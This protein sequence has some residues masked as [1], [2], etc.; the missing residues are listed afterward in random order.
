MKTEILSEANPTTRNYRNI[1]NCVACHA[2]LPK[3]EVFTLGL[4]PVVEFPSEPEG[5]KLEAPLYLCECPSCKLVQLQH[6]VTPDLL[7]RDFWYK[8]AT[9]GS[10]RSALQEIHD[11]VVREVNPQLGDAVLDIGANDGTLLSMFPVTNLRVGF[12]PARNLSQG[13]SDKGIIIVPEYFTREH[14]LPDWQGRFKAVTAISMFYD[15]ENPGEF[16]E[17]VKYAMNPNGVFIVQ[18]N[19]LGAML[20]SLDVGNIVHEHLAYYSLQSFAKLVQNHGMAI[21]RIEFNDVNGGSVR[22]TVRVGSDTPSEVMALIQSEKLKPWREFTAGLINMRG[23][24][25]MGITKA[26]MEKKRLAICG[27][28]T[29]GLALL[30]FLGRGKETFVVAGD[31]DSTKHGRYYGATGI[32]I[33]SEEEARQK[34]DVMLVLPWHFSSEIIEREKEW[35][36]AG[37]EL[38]LPLPEPTLISST[39][40][41]KL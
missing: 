17:A 2:P 36:E 12:E 13:A 5:R 21:S 30:Q 11:A 29:R 20:E 7:F 15:L 38:I 39:G 18:M 10:M 1:E 32:P 26:Q 28:S 9:T 19:Y 40:R 3:E 34:A 4:V 23:A 16:L 14:I 41:K 22:F 24:V 27:A 8:S 35:V 31:R 6:A 33:V 25:L 37:G